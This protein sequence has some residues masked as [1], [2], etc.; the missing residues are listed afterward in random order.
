M[1]FEKFHKIYK[2]NLETIKTKCHE[3]D[4]GVAAE[5]VAVAVAGVAAAAESVAPVINT[6]VQKP[7][8]VAIMRH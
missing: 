1:R 5:A 6:E 7:D 3:D 2:K 4:P 8:I